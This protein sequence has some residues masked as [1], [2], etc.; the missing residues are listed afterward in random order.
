LEREEMEEG[1]RK[2]DGWIVGGI[3]EEEDEGGR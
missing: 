2:L 3:V 1:R